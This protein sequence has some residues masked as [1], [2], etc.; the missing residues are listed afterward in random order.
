MNVKILSLVLLTLI[1]FNTWLNY[2][3]F[4][5]FDFYH[6]WGV[7]KAQQLSPEPLTS[8][9]VAPDT[10]ADILNQYTEKSSDQ[11]LRE[12][13][14][15]RRT[16]DLTGTPLLYS[17]F[18]I[19]P[20]NYTQAIISFRF[21]QLILFIF[22]VFL[23]GILQG[24]SD[25]FLTLSLILSVTF[26]PF[27]IDLRVGNLNTIQLFLI[28][29]STILVD[30]VNGHHPKQRL[31]SGLIFTCLF[32]FISLL[33][34]NLILI[35]LALGISFVVRYG[36]PK[37]IVLLSV[38]G[39]FSALLIVLTN[40]FLGSPRVW[41]DWYDLASSSKDRLIYPI[42]AGNYSATL[43]IS[44][45]YNINIF[46]ATASVAAFLAISMGGVI[47]ISAFKR[48][49]TIG[50]S[51]NV[52]LEIF[53]DPG[54][55]VSIA[56]T[57]TIALSPLVWVHYY[58]LLLAPIL[59]TINV[60]RYCKRGS[61]LSLLAIAASGGIILQLLNFRLELSPELH[62]TSFILGWIFVWGRILL[63]VLNL[64]KKEMA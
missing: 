1:S 39:A 21:L 43:L 9:Y 28:A 11:R 17:F 34:P 41:L 58:T 3:H 5:G 29:T 53:K 20:E 18:S 36:V 56:V 40:A 62:A 49:F 27:I 10:Y 54:L 47:L 52:L 25:N 42:E 44:Q 16:L 24:D 31:Y 45:L 6:Y 8:P 48:S 37:L 23:I 2:L 14:T 60:K 26:L 33:K 32:I 55:T 35:M 38:S 50:K 15:Y 13:N 46:A 30:R 12:A 19:L 57:V 22:A 63:I 51:F 4:P 7:A 61:W 59:L 64:P